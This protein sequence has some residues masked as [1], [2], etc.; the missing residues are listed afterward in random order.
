MHVAIALGVALVAIFFIVIIAGATPF[1]GIPILVVVFGFAA[2]Y[3]VVARRMA[4][5]KL[6]SD[7]PS[8]GEASYTPTVDPSDR[9]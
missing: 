1:V 5:R 4:E 9:S 7:V 3:A 6:D 2:L 8:T